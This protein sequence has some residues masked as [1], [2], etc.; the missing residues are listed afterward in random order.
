MKTALMAEIVLGLIIEADEEED[1]NERAVWAV[2]RLC[3]M[4]RDLRGLYRGKPAGE[5]GTAS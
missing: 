5:D 2:D 4:V 3:D 1:W